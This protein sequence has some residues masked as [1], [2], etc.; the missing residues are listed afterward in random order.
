MSTVH[1]YNGSYEPEEQTTGTGVWG[2]RAC[3]RYIYSGPPQKC[4]HCGSMRVR[5]LSEGELR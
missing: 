1:P 3:Q 4:P 2:C 5:E